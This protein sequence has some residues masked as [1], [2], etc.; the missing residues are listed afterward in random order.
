MPLAETEEIE[1]LDVDCDCS[2]LASPIQANKTS[3]INYNNEIKNY[4]PSRRTKLKRLS[5]MQKIKEIKDS[6]HIITEVA[7]KTYF[8]KRKFC[9]EVIQCRKRITKTQERMATMQ[10]ASFFQEYT[11]EF[12]R[13]QISTCAY[14]SFRE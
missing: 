3:N 10:T 5:S 4:D 8:L 13:S 2:L 6:T 7:E 12:E 1:F 14:A 11:F 9:E